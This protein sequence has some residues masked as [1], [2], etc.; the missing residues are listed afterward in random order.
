MMQKI[1]TVS[2]MDAYIKNKKGMK[3]REISIFCIKNSVICYLVYED[4]TN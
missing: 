1:A 3:K 2:N 4:S